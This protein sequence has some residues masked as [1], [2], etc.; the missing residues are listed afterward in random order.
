[1]S[2]TITLSKDEVKTVIDALTVH[3]DDLR[4]QSTAAGKKKR[5]G[6][7]KRQWL[8]LADDNYSVRERIMAEHV[9]QN[10]NSEEA[11]V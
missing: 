6:L 4:R 2:V 7:T 1:M 3:G 9:R 10:T 11:W 5:C 8:A